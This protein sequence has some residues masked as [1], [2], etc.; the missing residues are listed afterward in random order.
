MTLV[1][2]LNC[3]CLKSVPALVALAMLCVGVRAAEDGDW[4]YVVQR[5]DTLSGI[6]ARYLQGPNAW[7]PLARLNKIN[8]PRRLRINTPLHLPVAWL[9]TQASQAELAELVGD[10]SLRLAD[11]STPAAV[12]GQVLH[13][14][15][16]VSTAAGASATSRTS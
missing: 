15:D 10:V 7:R 8:N 4:V 5:G 16:T 9:G 3:C 11:G 13:S 2:P 6:A 14:L 12:I 1:A